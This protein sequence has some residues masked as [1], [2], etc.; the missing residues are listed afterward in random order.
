MKMIA[1]CRVVVGAEHR[2][3]IVAGAV[4]YL[5]QE[6]RLRTRTVPVTHDSDALLTADHKSCEI[7]CIRG[8]VVTHARIRSPIECPASIATEVL[9]LRNRQREIPLR[10]G[11]NDVSLPH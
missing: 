7:E 1:V 3:E 11:L 2:V 6:F 5:T 9:E 4:V 8:R 10:R